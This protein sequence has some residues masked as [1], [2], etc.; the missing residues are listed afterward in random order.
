MSK[1][2]RLVNGRVRIYTPGSVASEYT[3]LIPHPILPKHIR[4]YS[5]LRLKPVLISI[6]IKIIEC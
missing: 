1:V 5:F 4:L 2:L 3:V 6:I